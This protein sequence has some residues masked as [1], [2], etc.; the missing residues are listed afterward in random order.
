MSDLK[1]ILAKEFE[2]KDYAHA[3]MHAHVLERLAA[4]IY[5]TRTRRE[6]SQVDLAQASGIPQAKLS[7]LECAEVQSFTLA[8]LLKLARALD[9]A[10][11]V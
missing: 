10:V 9:V 3:Y 2:D 6:M 1:N 11:N 5:Q 4:Q 8:T 7:K